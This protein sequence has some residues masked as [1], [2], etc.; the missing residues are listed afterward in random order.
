MPAAKIPRFLNSILLPA[1]IV[2]LFTTQDSTARIG[3]TPA[4][5]AERYGT[6]KTDSA[7]QVFDKGFPLL[8][9]AIHK[10]YYFQGW[11]IRAA[12]PDAFGPAIRM[13]FHRGSKTG[14]SARLHRL[15]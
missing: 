11:R 14:Q 15:V 13:E 2:F 9:G 8:E 6:A 7:N 12:F 1:S 10:T 5:C 3:E 4:Q